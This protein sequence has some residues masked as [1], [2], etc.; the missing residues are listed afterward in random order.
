MLLSHDQILEY[1]DKGFII[2]DPF[3]VNHLGTTSY[4]VGLSE[5]F[6]RRNHQFKEDQATKILNTFDPEEIKDFWEYHRADNAKEWMKNTGVDLKNIRDEDQIFLIHPLETI[7]AS[8]I[9][10]IGG[11]EK[12]V[13]EMRGLSTL[14]RLEITICKCAGWGDIGYFNRWT[15]EITNH[16]Q[17]ISTILLVG[18]RIA[19][20][21]FREVKPIKGS[22]FE[23]DGRY[24]FSEELEELKKNWKP[25][26]MLPIIKVRE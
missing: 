7:L 18:M 1:L 2:I 26:M 15:M 16:D 6:Y 23:L 19:Q 22:Y 13:A 10:F 5:H 12:V 20:F 14:G 17:K 25:E 9:E 4:D 11:R 21:N 24:Q 3:N 8:T